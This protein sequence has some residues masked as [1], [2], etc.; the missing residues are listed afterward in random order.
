MQTDLAADRVAEKLQRCERLRK[1]FDILHGAK[2]RSDKK[3]HDSTVQLGRK[4]GTKAFADMKSHVGMDHRKA[5]THEQF[6][7]VVEYVTVVYGHSRCVCAGKNLGQTEAH[8]ATFA[9]WSG[10]ETCAFQISEESRDAR[11]IIPEN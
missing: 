11:S 1:A 9:Y 6:A 8:I 10:I 5:E 3:P 2:K 4:T 7:P